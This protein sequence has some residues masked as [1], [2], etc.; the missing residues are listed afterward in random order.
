[1]GAASLVSGKIVAAPLLITS[2]QVHKTKGG[3]L[4]FAHRRRVA[5]KKVL[6]RGFDRSKDF[7][8]AQGEVLQE[9]AKCHVLI[10][11]DYNNSQLDPKTVSLKCYSVMKGD[12]DL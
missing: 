5:C 2:F 4:R 7:L 6:G 1:M 11:C 3:Y 8:H 9:N 12:T 10:N